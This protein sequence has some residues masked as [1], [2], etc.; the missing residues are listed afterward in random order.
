MPSLLRQETYRARALRAHA[1]PAETALWALLRR[2]ALGAKFR[3][4]HPLG[5][6]IVD[7]FCC[8]AALVV[9]VDG[10]V[11]DSERAQRHDA[12]RDAFLGQCGL[13]VLRLRNDLVL[14]APE[15]A[16]EIIR[17]ALADEAPPPSGRGLGGG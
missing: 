12:V 7:F 15:R 14:Q 16:L 8:D 3:R 13:R 9:E 5:P 1:T 10:G 11:H 4:Q 17:A 2:R 6:Y